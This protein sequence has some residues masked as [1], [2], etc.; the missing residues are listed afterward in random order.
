[1]SEMKNPKKPQDLGAE[2]K[3]R[4]KSRRMIKI[5]S[6]ENLNKPLSN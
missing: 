2:L 5:N 3:N 4:A 1:M 6:L